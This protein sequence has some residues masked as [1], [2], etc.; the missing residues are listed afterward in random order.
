[1]RTKLNIWLMAA[2]VFGLGMSVTSC[3]DNDDEKTEAEKEQEAQEKTS[4][5]WNIVELLVS[6][7]DKS[8]L[9]AHHTSNALTRT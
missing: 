8:I 4:K 9:R 1:M 6:V 2:L 7:G 5:F 3:K